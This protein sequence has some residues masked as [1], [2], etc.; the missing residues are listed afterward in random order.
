VAETPTAETSSLEGLERELIG[1][2]D[3][4]PDLAKLEEVRVEALGRKG[5]V[6]ELMAKL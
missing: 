2:I 5:R 1:A 3:A 6:S 4:A